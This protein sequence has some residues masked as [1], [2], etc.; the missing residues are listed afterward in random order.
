MSDVSDPERRLLVAVDMEHYS[1]RDNVLQFR[2]QAGLQSHVATACMEVG[3]N[4]GDWDIQ[5]SGDG[6]LVVLPEGVSE[7]AVVAR[8]A[9][10]LNRLLRQHNNGLDPVARIRMRVAVHEGLV[11]RDG[12]NGWAGEAVVHVCRLVDSM[13]GKQ[14]LDRFPQADVVLIVSNR[15]YHDVVRP[16]RDL[17]PDQFLSVSSRVNGKE[18]ERA[19]WIYV[20]DENAALAGTSPESGHRRK[21]EQQAPGNPRGNRQ[22]APRELAGRQVFHNVTTHGPAAFGNG[23][24][25]SGSSDSEYDLRGLQ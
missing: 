22:V 6:Q 7:R 16:Y 13:E 14:A 8:L 17:R 19:A 20:P 24:T 12:A 23:N 1:R 10:A 25:V 21:V 2:A 11:H 4:R 3:L 18:G 5:S 15:I 9:P